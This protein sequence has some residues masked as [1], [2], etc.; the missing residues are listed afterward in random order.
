MNPVA[1][2]THLLD[3]EG[4]L[5]HD[6]EGNLRDSLCAI[7]Q[8]EYNAVQGTI[9]AGLPPDEYARAQSWEGALRAALAVVPRYWRSEQS[10]HKA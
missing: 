3:L 7:L 1:R 8:E 10:R 4:R 9:R 6:R 2:P 5:A